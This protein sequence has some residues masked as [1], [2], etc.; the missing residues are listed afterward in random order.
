MLAHPK[1]ALWL[2]V[3]VA[4]PGCGRG[5]EALQ[6]EETF[7]W[8]RQPI[9]FSP[10]PSRWYREGDNGGG[11]LG[12][13]F[14]LRGGG[15]QC[16]SLAAYTWFAERDRRAVLARLA[17]R[18]DSLEQ[19]EF[20]RELSL[21][22]TR[23]DD[24]LSDQEAAAS[25]AVNAALDRA[26]SDELAGQPGFVATDLEDASRAA[27]GY[28]MTLPEILPRIRLRPERMQEPARWLLGYERDTVIAGQPAFAG[29]DTLITPERPLLYHQVYWVVRGCA[30]QAVYQGTRE[31]LTTFHRVLDS[32]RFPEP[33]RAT[34][35]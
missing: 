34:P 25:L 9:S 35:R 4:L 13:R 6:P 14:I 30:F 12:V 3:L 20:L 5:H 10:P 32:I 2:A 29:D 17:G 24:P 26:V 31:N 27:A 15:G 33:P 8:C 16:I 7:S 11:T 18:R 19:R 23:T 28:E 21:A 22:R 1:S